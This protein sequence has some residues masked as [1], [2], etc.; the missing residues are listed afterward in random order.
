MWE[1]GAD[2]LTF[3]GLQSDTKKYI[4]PLCYPAY[5]FIIGGGNYGKII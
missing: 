4:D 2:T 3:F 5:N 1:D